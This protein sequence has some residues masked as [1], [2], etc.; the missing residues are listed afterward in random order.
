MN[1]IK[2]G[3][4][5]L[6]L[7]LS[8]SSAYGQQTPFSP[9]SYY[10]FTP[11][12]FNPAI[13][14]SKDFT[15]LDIAATIQGQDKSQ[16]IS[17]NTRLARAGSSYFAAPN[18]KNFTNIG[19]GGSVF[20]DVIGP[21]RSIGLSLAVS[22]HLPLDKKKL[23]FLAGGIAVKGIYN[24]LD[25]VPDTGAPARDGFIPNSDIGLYYYRQNFYSG[26]SVTNIFG[27]LLDNADQ[28]IYNI[29][30]SRQYL[31]V[32]GYKIILSKSLNVILE[33]SIIINTNDSLDFKN[34]EIYN[35]MLKLFLDEFCIGTY[36]HDYNKISVFF[37]YKF[38]KIYL[39]T[40]VDFPK[41]A[42]FYKKELYVEIA[43]GINLSG[44]KPSFAEKWHW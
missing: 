31:F 41:D 17:G 12:L 35:P 4:S 23:S 20:N 25:S 28:S 39:G 1:Q 22:Y 13:A 24:I 7:I 42:P 10:V 8:F 30:V 32:A 27:N 36:L 26:I 18:F 11:F 38:P 5:V 44:F 3:L 43:L 33:P 16:I 40:F 34:K 6:I 14:G 37:E 19:V 15:S 2:K 21:S 29:P 9:V